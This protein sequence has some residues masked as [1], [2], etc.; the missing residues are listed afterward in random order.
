MKTKLLVVLFIFGLFNLSNAQVSMLG[1]ALPGELYMAQF[2]LYEFQQQAT[3][4]TGTIKFRQG[5]SWDVNWGSNSF[6]IGTGVQDG[7]DI[8]VTAG[9][10]VVS[11]NSS[12]GDYNFVPTTPA[13]VISIVGTGVNGWPE[14]QTT[15]EI[16]LFT[17]DGISYVINNL[18]VTNGLVKF[19]KDLSWDVNWGDSTFP[20]GM[21]IL[22][23]PNIPTTAGTYDVTFNINNATYTFIPSSHV[24]PSIGIWG[25]A[26]DAQNGYAGADVD[27]TTTDGI[28]YTLSGFYFSSGQAYFRQDNATT[29]VWGGT[30]YPT[31]TAVLTG[32]SLFIPGGE[33]FV[34]FNRITGEYSFSFPSIGI[35]GT[36][37][38]GFEV[39]DTDLI[40]TDGFNYTIQELSLSAGEVKFRKDNSWTTNWGAS[41]FPGG[42]G[43]QDGVNIPIENPGN[44]NISFDR[45]SGQYFF[46]QLL[47][48]ENFM[49]NSVLL[50]PNPT[51]NVWN[52]NSATEK[53]N[54]FELY[55]CN[56]KKIKSLQP[57]DFNFSLDGSSLSSGLYFG[58]IATTSFSKSVKL[59][60]L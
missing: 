7:A 14:N 29:F 23:G 31:G 2:G 12:S 1:T 53:I 49:I 56:G 43:V 9:T 52:F 11:F 40:T 54:S 48:T 44:Y 25:P 26:V 35:L 34:T 57:N 33:H 5:S 8:P 13:P 46:M 15:P 18:V 39:A 47:G 42:T 51:N 36:A 59:V 58:K 45:L 22:N 19:R 38:N 55:D 10:Y 60:K 30:N 28:I 27:M 4:T 24:F 50:Y 6:P 32:P 21:G 3:F 16:T 41:A 17:N 20:I 37:L